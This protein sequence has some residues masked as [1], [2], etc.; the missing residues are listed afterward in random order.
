VGVVGKPLMEAS[1]PHAELMTA[2]EGRLNV[3]STRDGHI[4]SISLDG[5]GDPTALLST[6]SEDEIRRYF[7]SF[8]ELRMMVMDAETRRRRSVVRCVQIR[9]LAGAGAHLLKH[10]SAVLV[11]KR[12]LGEALDN[13]PESTHCVLFLNTP[14][15]FT[16]LWSIIKPMLSARSQAKCQ[17]LGADYRTAV[18]DQAGLTVLGQLY[19]LNGAGHTAASVLRAER[20]QHTTGVGVR[21]VYVNAAG[22]MCF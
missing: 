14:S 4:I 22:H 12:I 10:S 19:E 15:V 9:D 8:F 20:N 2:Q 3:G 18:I 13:Y 7:R 1:L 6:N 5:A 17:F 21:S 11:L 16:A